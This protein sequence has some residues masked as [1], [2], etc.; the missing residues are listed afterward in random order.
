MHFKYV[1]LHNVLQVDYIPAITQL[2]YSFYLHRHSLTYR[3]CSTVQVLAESVRA[4]KHR[5][6]VK[7]KFALSQKESAVKM[8]L[9]ELE[10]AGYSNENKFGRK[11]FASEEPVAKMYGSSLEFE[12]ARKKVQ[13]STPHRINANITY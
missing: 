2:K 8:A 6:G 5:K 11:I 10:S 3:Y 1:Q 7:N 12:D 9:A 13:Y 4:D